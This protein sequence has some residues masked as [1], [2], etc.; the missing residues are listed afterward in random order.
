MFREGELQKNR[1]YM[2]IQDPKKGNGKILLITEFFSPTIGGSISVYENIY[3][4]YPKDSVW[5]LTPKL[6]GV[7]KREN[8]KGIEVLRIAFPLFF[9]S[10]F[11]MLWRYLW[12]MWQ[13]QKL[14]KKHQIQEIHC[15]QV[16]PA[17]MMAWLIYRFFKVPYFVY[18]HG[19]EIAIGSRFPFRRRWM[20]RIY[21]EALGV[22]VNSRFTGELIKNLGVP[23]EKIKVIYWGVEPKTLNYSGDVKKLKEKYDCSNKKVVLTVSRLIRRKGHYFVLKV[24]KKFLAKDPNLHYLIVGDGEEKEYLHHQIKDFSL[25]ENVTVLGKVSDEALLELYSMCDL[26]VMPNIELENGEVEGF[27]LVFIEAGVMKKPTIGGNSGGTSDAIEK[28]QTGLIVDPYD[29]LELEKGMEKLLYDSSS[30]E[31]MGA[32]AYKR[33]EHFFVWDKVFDRIEHFRQ[34]QR[35]EAS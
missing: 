10:K 24:F 12:G 9:Y 1:G 14:I 21:S 7:P 26:F 11:Q 34:Q 23:E 32:A 5:V 31:Q 4:Q 28:D 16:T 25:D 2:G 6:K 15:D 13:A 35:I 3:R 22:F 19:E 27:G 30:A 18:G 20:R 33:I 29:T 17:G 8:L